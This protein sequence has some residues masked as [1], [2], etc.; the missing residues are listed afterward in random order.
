MMLA[1]GRSMD[2]SPT[3]EMKMQFTAGLFWNW[4]R[5]RMRSTP[6]VGPYMY[7]FISR[8][9]YILRANTLSL[10]TIILSPRSSWKRMRNW[11]IWN[12]VGFMIYS[13]FFCWTVSALRYSRKKRG[14]ILHHT[15][16][17]CTL[18][19][20][21]LRCRSSQFAS[22]NLGPIRK[23]R[24]SIR[25]SSRTSVA[26]RPSLQCA[27]V[28]VSTFRKM[29]AGT[30]CTSS[31]SM[32]P[33]SLPCSCAIT[34]AASS[35]RFPPYAIMVYVEMTTPTSGILSLYSD[36]K[37]AIL[38]SSMVLHSLNWCFHCSTDTPDVQR[39]S[40]LFLTV[41]HAVM[42]TSV[43][44]APHGSTMM[45]DLARPFPNILLRLRSW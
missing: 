20:C 17:H 5:M 36:V 21:P 10:N 15:S 24:S 40:V 45:P 42:P 23:L 18:A 25:S 12:L 14:A 3:L 19:M 29:R 44:P 43:F 16:T 1:S 27:C 7:G 30:T 11:H 4:L 38:W 34:R 26:V 28:T 41:Q 22:Y 9:A 6:L 8:S 2:V 33:H 35:D 13:I 39:T 31:S 32:M 37:R